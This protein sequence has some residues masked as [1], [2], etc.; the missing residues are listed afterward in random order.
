[1]SSIG[2]STAVVVDGLSRSLWNTG[3]AVMVPP[4]LNVACKFNDGDCCDDGMDALERDSLVA[5]VKAAEKN[6]G[7]GSPK[8]DIGVL[9]SIGLVWAMIS[10]FPTLA[11]WLLGFK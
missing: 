9:A 5:G 8:Y 10:P 2:P 6:K 3:S 11:G 1:M 7:W 4:S